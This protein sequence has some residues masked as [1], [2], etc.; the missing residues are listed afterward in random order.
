[1]RKWYLL[2]TI[3]LLA[4]GC[5]ENHL[6]DAGTSAADGGADAGGR[7][8]VDGA[9][10]SCEALGGYPTCDVLCETGCPGAELCHQHFHICR[11]FSEA[12]GCSVTLSSTE[13]DYPDRTYCKDGQVCVVADDVLEADGAIRGL[14]VREEYCREMRAAHI[15][16]QCRWSDETGFDAGPPDLATC[17]RAAHGVVRNCGGPCGGCNT[18]LWL[19]RYAVDASCTGVSERRG[20][21]VCTFNGSMPCS[22]GVPGV[23]SS[24]VGDW[25]EPC[26]CLLLQLPDGTF[27]RVGYPTLVSTCRDYQAYFPDTVRCMEPEAWRPLD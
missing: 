9:T 13:S 19:R 7:F 10:S 6:G 15:A 21:G 2:P 5:F 26:A 1:M 25:G 22:R 17:P 16:G 27:N 14:C 20:F 12:T 23:T 18:D 24:C 3:G 8:D 11:G 4:A